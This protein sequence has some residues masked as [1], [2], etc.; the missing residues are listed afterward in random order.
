MF[1]LPA[2]PRARPPPTNHHGARTCVSRDAEHRADGDQNGVG[3]H[4]ANVNQD[5][6]S[7]GKTE[8]N[9]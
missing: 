9:K 2:H 4:Y 3:Q 1:L 8:N 6:E 5:V 7:W